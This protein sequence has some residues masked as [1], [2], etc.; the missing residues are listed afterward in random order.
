MNTGVTTRD[1]ILQAGRRLVTQ[2]GIAALNMRLL[3][4]ECDI[5]LG[6]L[7]NYFSD[8]DEL[9]IAVVES[10]WAEIFRMEPDDAADS[11]F[12]GYIARLF[13]CVRRGAQAYPGFLSAHAVGIA[14]SRKGEAK[15]A[16]ER[17]FERLKDG[18]LCALRADPAVDRAAFDG[19]FTESDLADLILGNVLL[20]LI[21]DR[22]DCAAL[23]ALVR[24]A[25]YR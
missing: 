2:Q 5:A 4:S 13:D 20:L 9:L 24:R 6:T 21:E 22:Q 19:G 3:A 11:S 12:A 7:Y 14:Q 25:L 1:A 8:K 16:M 23:V 17:C 18:M 10:V 15:C